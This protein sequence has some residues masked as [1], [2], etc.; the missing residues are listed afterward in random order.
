[1]NGYEHNNVGQYNALISNQ[2]Y[3]MANNVAHVV[4]IGTGA[5]YSDMAGNY[6][7]YAAFDATHD[8]HLMSSV[9]SPNNLNDLISAT[10]KLYITL[11][12]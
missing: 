8:T 5:S 3:Y 7:D 6:L 9:D 1:M 4:P 10:Q 11:V 2:D 12:K